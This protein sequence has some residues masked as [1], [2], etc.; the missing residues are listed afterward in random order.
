MKLQLYRPVISKRLT[1]KFGQN[2]ACVT[3]SGRIV[4]KVGGVCPAGSWEY[5]P[6]IG[7]KGHNGYDIAAWSGEPCYHAG[8]Y[9]GWMKTEKDSAGGI[10]V[11]VISNE[12]VKLIDGTETYIKTRYWHLKAPVGHDGKQVTLGTQIGLCD[13]TGASS[14]SHLHFGVK[15]CDKNGVSLYPGNGWYGC[16][17]P[18][19]Y[20]EYEF[21][22]KS[23]AAFWLKPPVP[24]TPQEKKELLD[25]LSLAQRALNL[26]LE[27]KR[28]S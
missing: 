3:G 26:L 27:L 2:E 18:E 23:A 1:Q 8:T 4:G 10:G 20:M 25:Q 7:L 5:Y 17:D 19:P 11:D 14:G 24:L 12:P 16:I 22:A 9:D 13:N 21:D 15:P 6:T 28:L